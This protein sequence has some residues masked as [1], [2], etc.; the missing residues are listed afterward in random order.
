MKRVHLILQGKG[1]VGKTFAASLLAQYHSE[2][3]LD[4]LCL[5]TDPVNATFSGYTALNVERL[6]LMDG[7][8]LDSRKFDG[9]MSCLLQKEAHFVVDNGAASFLPLS[10]YLIENN[11]IEMLEAAQKKVLI[12]TLITGS[13][14]MRD[15]MSGFVK[16]A[17]NLPEQA[18]IV[19]WLNEFFGP[20]V[21]EDGKQFEDMKAYKDYK[22]RVA[23]I[24]RIPQRTSTTFGK[25][26][27]LML[28]AR[29]TFQEVQTNPDFELMA[30]QRLAIVKRDLF[31]QIAL[32]I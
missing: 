7:T 22:G 18:Q 14:G 15:T 6:D 17:Q 9:M 13:M 19:V 3:G 1:G 32:V 8:E 4:V 28:H 23:G 21:S 25:D 5:D 16:L 11:V 12:H 31:E 30:K 24:I 10:N 29:Q 27:Q 20:I 2:K 26:V